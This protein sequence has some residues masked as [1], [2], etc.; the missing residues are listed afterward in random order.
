MFERYRF[1]DNRISSAATPASLHREIGPGR[2]TWHDP[3]MVR[4]ILTSTGHQHRATDTRKNHALCVT[5]VTFQIQTHANPPFPTP[6]HCEW[7][8]AIQSRS[9]PTGQWKMRSR[10]GAESAEKKEGQRGSHRGTKAQRWRDQPRANSPVTPA[11]SRGPALAD[12]TAG[13][14]V[15]PGVTGEEAPF[16]SAPLLCLRAFV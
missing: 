4:L 5:L 9:E 8:E 6:R 1:F 7:S 14:R 3:C 10:R 13:P 2:S 12:V 15:E 16:R 11:L